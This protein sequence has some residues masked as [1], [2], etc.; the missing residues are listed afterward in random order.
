[1]NDAIKD[2]LLFALGFCCGIIFVAYKLQD[3]ELTEKIKCTEKPYFN[4][5]GEIDTLYVYHFQ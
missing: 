4:K 1:M 3:I 5:K 2:I